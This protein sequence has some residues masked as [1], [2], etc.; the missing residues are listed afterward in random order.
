[1]LRDRFEN[2][3]RT[4]ARLAGIGLGLGTVG[5]GFWLNPLAAALAF[6]GLFLTA[7]VLEGWG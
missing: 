4:A 6:G 5:Y 1:M 7:W 3:I 2:R